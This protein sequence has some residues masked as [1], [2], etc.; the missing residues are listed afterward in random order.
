MPAGRRGLLLVCHPGSTPASGHQRYATAG[1]WVSPRRHGRMLSGPVLATGWAGTVAHSGEAGM[2][3]P[4]KSARKPRGPHLGPTS[5][6]DVRASSQRPSAVS[7]RERAQM[8]HASRAADRGLIL[9]RN[10]AGPAAWASA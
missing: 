2:E 3:E 6:V 4:A 5:V 10:D 7:A 1:C 9:G 8:D